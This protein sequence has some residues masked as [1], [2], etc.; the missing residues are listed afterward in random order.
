MAGPLVLKQSFPSGLTSGLSILQASSGLKKGASLPGSVELA[1]LG[2][3]DSPSA[4]SVSVLRKLV[5][6]LWTVKTPGAGASY[7]QLKLACP[8]AP[9]KEREIKLHPKFVLLFL[10]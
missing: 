4:W 3:S 1:F 10:Q 6:G 8:A 9:T 2:L 5:P 7:L